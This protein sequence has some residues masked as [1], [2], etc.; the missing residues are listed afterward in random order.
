MKL[1]Q[2]QILL[3]IERFG[4]IRAASNDLGLSQPAVTKA[5]RQIEGDLGVAIFKRTPLGI[6]AT[7]DGLALLRRATIIQSEIV[8]MQEEAQQRRG[9]EVG[10][11]RPQWQRNGSCLM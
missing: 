2:I 5:L 7:E 6:A 3:T 10:H 8:K 9:A 11:I 4:S 1:R